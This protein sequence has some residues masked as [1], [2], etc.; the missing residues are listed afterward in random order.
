MSLQRLDVIDIF[1]VLIYSLYQKILT[2]E[3]TEGKM[4]N[5]LRIRVQEQGAMVESAD[6]RGDLAHQGSDQPLPLS[7]IRSTATRRC[8]PR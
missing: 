4:S 5:G 8:V 2:Q 6:V 3:Q 1:L 7:V